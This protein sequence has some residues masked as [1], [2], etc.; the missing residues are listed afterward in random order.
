MVK[1]STVL[2]FRVEKFSSTLKTG[3]VNSSETTRLPDCVTWHAL[4]GNDT[5]LSI[6]QR[7]RKADTKTKLSRFYL[8]VCHYGR[9]LWR[10]WMSER[11]RCSWGRWPST[12]QTT[13]T[14][15]HGFKR[16]AGTDNACVRFRSDAYTR[17]MVCRHMY[18]WAAS[19]KQVKVPDS[20]TFSPVTNPWAI[21]C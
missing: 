21:V 8:C 15:F 18:W 6:W 10:R 14:A 19:Y 12:A 4:V 17:A 5:S 1:E 9:L 13:L 3:V 20:T 7:I 11:W 2:T 16:L